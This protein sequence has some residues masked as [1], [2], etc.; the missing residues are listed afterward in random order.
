MTRLTNLSK[1]VIYADKTSNLPACVEKC[2]Q[3]IKINAKSCLD[4]KTFNSIAHLRYSTDSFLKIADVLQNI[5]PYGKT[6]KI[7]AKQ[8]DKIKIEYA[9][10][11]RPKK[12]VKM[13]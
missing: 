4:R 2:K 7:Y 5:A 8:G 10:L 13:Y 1:S 6:L 3:F 11:K 9:E 12:R